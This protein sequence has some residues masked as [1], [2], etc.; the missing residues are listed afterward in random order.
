MKKIILFLLACSFSAALLAQGPTNA[1]LFAFNKS[2]NQKSAFGLKV[3]G[4]WSVANLATSG[5][6]YYNTKGTDHYFHQMNIVFNSVNVLIVASGLISKQKNELS[7]NKTLQSQ[8][9]TESTFI[10]NAALDLFYISAGFYLT[11]KAKNNF[12]D[13]DRFKGWGNSL[14]MQGGFLFLFDTTMF[15]V[16]KKNGK[17]LY[18][19]MDKVSIG[20]SGLGFKLGIQL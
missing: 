6:M 10:A 9:N 14:I 5:I 17:K 3:L 19:L 8:A 16:H 1:E 2:R 15:V 13:H 11:E 18:N 7:L 20:T 4:A 12:K